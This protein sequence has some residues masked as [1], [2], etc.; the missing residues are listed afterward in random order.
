MQCLTPAGN[1]LGCWCVNT[2]AIVGKTEL[3]GLGKADPQ[4]VRFFPEAGA[5]AIALHYDMLVVGL[6][7]V[8]HH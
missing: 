2:V 7:S 6:G 4:H 8:S 3:T 1:L 5:N